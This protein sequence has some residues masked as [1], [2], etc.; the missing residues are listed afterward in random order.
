MKKF[1]ILLLLVLF[2]MAVG[3]A[4][5]QEAK[6]FISF[7]EAKAKVEGIPKF[8]AGYKA[9]RSVLLEK[10]KIAKDP[11][12]ANN[13][14]KIKESLVI[15][16]STYRNTKEFRTSMDSLWIVLHN[17][18]T[19]PSI[20]TAEGWTADQINMARSWQKKYSAVTNQIKKID[21][22][23]PTDSQVEGLL[24]TYNIDVMFLISGRN[25]VPVF[26]IT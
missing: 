24:I 20:L 7:S 5:A 26:F 9:Q 8:I 6:Y 21:S 19:D 14:E 13:P 22:N 2:G 17:S 11:A 25:P 23:I 18:W 1:R 4:N 3:H 16:V 12:V 15:L 10:W